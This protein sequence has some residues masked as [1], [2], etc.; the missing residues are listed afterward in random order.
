MSVNVN[1]SVSDQFYRYKMRL[2]G[3][4]HIPPNI[5]VVS[6]EHRPSLM[7]RMTVTLSMDLMRRIS[8]KTCWM[9]SLKNL[10]SVLSVRILKQICMSIQ[11]SKQ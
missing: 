5:L 9:D 10:F 3:L 1:R 6:W 7:L 2:I 11:R 8:C 4:Q